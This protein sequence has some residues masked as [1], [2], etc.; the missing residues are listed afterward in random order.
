MSKEETEARQMNPKTYAEKAVTI[1]TLFW[2]P[3]VKVEEA[4]TVCFGYGYPEPKTG[5]ALFSG[6][7]GA[8]NDGIDWPAGKLRKG[9]ADLIEHVAEDCIFVI[10]DIEGISSET[11]SA[12]ATS[13]RRHFQIEG[14]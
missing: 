2:N 11:Q 1:H 8:V 14:N 5:V 3:E 10:A 13:I 4:G 9:I 12:I 6:P 7:R